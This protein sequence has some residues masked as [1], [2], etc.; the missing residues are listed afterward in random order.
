MARCWLLR[1]HALPPTIKSDCAFYALTFRQLAGTASLSNRPS[2]RQGSRSRR[3]HTDHQDIASVHA[4]TEETLEGTSR[5]QQQPTIPHWPRPQRWHRPPI[6]TSAPQEQSKYFWGYSLGAEARSI[7][8]RHGTRLIEPRQG[9][10]RPKRPG[11]CHRQRAGAVHRPQS[12]QQ[13]T[14][15]KD[16]KSTSFSRA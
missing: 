15:R 16:W 13:Y 11:R 14:R 3:H 5:G 10:N 12:C 9:V 4:D 2:S 7:W 8:N 6:G 1:R